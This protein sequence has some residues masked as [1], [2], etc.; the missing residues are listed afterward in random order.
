MNK[1]TKIAEAI[2]EIKQAD[3]ETLRQTIEKWYEHTRTQG[4]RIGAQMMSIGVD[5]IIKKHTR[6]PAKVSLR[7]YERMTAEIQKLIAVPL[8]QQNDSEEVKADNT[9]VE[10]HHNDGTAE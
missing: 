6:K 5:N 7:D 9:I 8:T 4:M 3:E 10:D 1:E 2:E